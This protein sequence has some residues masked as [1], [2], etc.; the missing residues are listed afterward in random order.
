MKYS[1]ILLFLFFLL[2]VAGKG[3]Q[4]DYAASFSLRNL[5]TTPWMQ[6]IPED[7]EMSFQIKNGKKQCVL[8]MTTDE[9]VT[10]R[11]GYIA[12]FYHGE[13]DKISST[14]SVFQLTL[15]PDS[16]KILDVPANVSSKQNHASDWNNWI[17]KEELEP[18]TY[19][20]R[21]LNDGYGI[22]TSSVDTSERILMPTT[23]KTILNKYP[24]KIWKRFFN[25]LRGYYNDS[26]V[27]EMS[28]IKAKS[29]KY[30]RLLCSLLRSHPNFLPGYYELQAIAMDK[31][32]MI[33]YLNK[34]LSIYP[35]DIR[36]L[37]FRALA[38]KETGDKENAELFFRKAKRLCT[39]H[40]SVQPRD[41][42]THIRLLFINYQLT[43]DKE[44]L[45]SRINLLK[46]Q[47]PHLT[48]D[49]GE[50]IDAFSQIISK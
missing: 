41:W 5:D 17:S 50:S 11:E 35:T 7:F 32:E 6:L 38:A 18:V 40:L 3:Q 46:K 16:R 9:F 49:E 33:T 42:N 48:K 34:G 27:D 28:L 14:D 8:N 39:E 21:L 37:T 43:A 45:C 36:L 29:T 4:V 47:I 12:Y 23:T 24:I 22:L 1:K 31:V 44:Q 25:I 10:A 20:V 13:T 15:Q 26:P 30:V 2:S 19:N